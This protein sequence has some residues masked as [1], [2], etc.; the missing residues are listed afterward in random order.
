MKNFNMT[1]GDDVKIVDQEEVKKALLKEGW[2]ESKG[3][4]SV[5]E[6]K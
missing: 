2:K 6:D 4:P 3:K 5:K 1:K